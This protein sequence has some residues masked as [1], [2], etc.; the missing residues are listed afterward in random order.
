M[1]ETT[2][3]LQPSRG[4]AFL[5]SYLPRACGVATFTKDLSDAVAKQAS[6]HQSVIVTAVNDLEEG[7]NYP[8][9]VK[10]EVRQDH[11]IDYSRA[12]DFLNF[13]GI[14]V[15]CLQHE[16]GIFGGKWGANVLTL[17]RDLNRPVVATCH[18]VLQQPDPGQKEVFL[19]I[20]ARVDKLVVMTAKASHFLEEIYKVDRDKIVLIPHGIHDVP[21]IDPNYYKDKFGVEGRRVLLTFGLLSR[22]KGIEYMIEALPQIVEKHP[23]TTY[24][25][26]GATHPSI[27]R[28]EGESYRLELQRRVRDLG[29]EEH[30]VFHPRFVELD[31]LLEYIGATDIFVA[32]YLDLDQITSGALSY[33]AGAG[34]AVVSTPFWH[35]E[36]LLAEGRG[37]LVPVE[38]SGALASEILSL[39]DD[40]VAHNSMRKRAYTYCR[41]MVWSAV[42]RSYLELFDEV[43]SRVPKTVSTASAMRRPI[44]PTNLPTPKIDHLL[45]LS[46]DTGPAHHARHT[47]P[48][49]SHGYRLEDA[50]G[51]LLVSSKYYDL[52]NDTDAQRLAEICA[53]L[54][55]T[56]IG[57]GRNV[58]GAL[59][60]ARHSKGRATETDLA[61]ALWALGYVA[62]H[63]PSSISEPAIDTYHQLMQA[64]SFTDARAAAYGV[65]GAANYLVRFPGAFQVKRFLSKQAAIVV[66]FCTESGGAGAGWIE[67]WKHADWPLAVQAVSVAARRLNDD[68]LRETSRRLIAEIREVTSDGTVFAKPGP[69][70]TEEELPV[71]AAVYID[72]LGAAYW[73]GGDDELIHSIRSA[74]DWF[75]GANRVGKSLYDFGTGGCHDA[76]TAG[77]LN[78]NQGAEATLYCLMAFLTLYRLASLAPVELAAEES[79]EVESTE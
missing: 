20:A 4:I 47:L 78:R 61:K 45:R 27:V 48:D 16:F 79:A 71:S 10:F 55:Q 58:S 23:K 77:G 7:Y 57:D 75:L 43:T 56:L 49:W 39:L 14:D 70:P 1:Y 52:F 13:G 33:A 65:L 5:A 66:E 46:D 40:E 24:L 76:L 28:D 29:L 8:D 6:R 26:L 15:L 36:E 59:D 50:A 31:E 38:D 18:T 63:G 67:R 68:A 72:A 17:L 64:A 60:Y 73:D 30:V 62:H 25:V 3:T 9:R 41:N 34:K 2:D 54:L 12:A 35:A 11:Q 19:E 42:A 44:S 53:A 51:V 69:N 22:N 37:R 74:A 21:F 32:P